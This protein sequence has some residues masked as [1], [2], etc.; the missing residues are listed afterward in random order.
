M[1]NRYL[2]GPSG[3]ALG[4]RLLPAALTFGGLLGPWVF[5]AAVGI[6]SDL[7]VNY[8]HKEEVLGVGIVVALVAFFA[9][10]AAMWVWIFRGASK[11]RQ[12]EPYALAGDDRAREAA[13]YTLRR[14]FRGDARLRAFYTLGL[15]AERRGDFAEAEDLFARACQ[16]VP[17]G[18]ATRQRT[19]ITTLALGHLSFCRAASNQA[20]LCAQSLAEAHRRIPTLYVQGALD[21][22]FDDS[23]WGGMG[24]MS[25]NRTVD[26]IEARRDPRA[27]VALAGALLAFKNGH[28]RQCVDAASAEDGMLRH[29]LLPHEGELI[30]LVK[31]ES[32]AKLSGGE[33]RGSAMATSASEWVARARG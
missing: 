28:Y 33:Y 27:M 6:F 26:E 23:V 1:K 32:L 21:G 12:A 5:F 10:V 19:R 25:P 7:F 30:E 8:A 13:H 31:A 4:S 11:L 17:M 16:A 3:A 24:A 20:E 9:I 22:L 18:L 2:L 29:N 15:L 14:V